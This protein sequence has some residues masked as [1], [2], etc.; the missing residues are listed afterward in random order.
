MNF[1]CLVLVNVVFQV[2]AKAP[3]RYRIFAFFGGSDP[4]NVRYYWLTGNNKGNGAS[5]KASI[6]IAYQDVG[7]AP[8]AQ[9]W[10]QVP[11][12]QCY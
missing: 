4:R 7:V 6:P 11:D 12:G 3:D 10:D 5:C 8:W 1:L 2:T 9:E